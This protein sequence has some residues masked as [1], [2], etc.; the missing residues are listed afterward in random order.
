MDEFVEAPTEFRSLYRVG[1]VAAVMIVA[2]ILLAIPIF[3]LWPPPGGLLPTPAAVIDCFTLLQRNWLVGLLD[4]DLVMIASAVL[5][6]PIYLALYAS[7]RRTSP[8]FMAIALVLGLVGTAAYMVVNPAFSMLSL[9][10][11]Y[12]AATSDAQRSLFVAAGQAIL[13]TYQGTGFDLYYL[14]GAVA[15]LITSVVMRRSTIFGKA[16]A[17]LGIAAGLLMIVPPTAGTIGLYLSLLS[18]LPAAIWYIL[19]ARRLFQFG[20]RVSKKE[21]KQN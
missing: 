5:G 17:Y 12:A 19:I 18:L 15:T 21:A 11:H 6:V 13:A 9:S 7:L 1:A 4:L 10:T 16:T 2:C 14:L 3:L 8:S 20:Q